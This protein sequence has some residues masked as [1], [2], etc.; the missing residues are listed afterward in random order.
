MNVNSK[1]FLVNYQ[2]GKSHFK[3]IYGQLTEAIES[4]DYYLFDSYPIRAEAWIYDNE[5]NKLC[6][7]QFDR[8]EDILS[9]IKNFVGIKQ[10]HK[11]IKK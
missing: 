10:F 6:F 1:G 7:N 5:D 4:I 3:E 8:K 2:I 9:G 11:G